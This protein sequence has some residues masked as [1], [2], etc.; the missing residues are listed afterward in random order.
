M[1]Q[2]KYVLIKYGLTIE[3]IKH[4]GIIIISDN[5]YNKMRY[6]DYDLNEAIAK[7][8]FAQKDIWNIYFQ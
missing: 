2:T 1:Y 5:N 6:V 8:M 7:G 4:N 3:I